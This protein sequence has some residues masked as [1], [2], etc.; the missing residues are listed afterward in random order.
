M[1]VVFDH[2]IIGDLAGVSHPQNFAF[3]QPTY[4]D[5]YMYDLS[6][7]AVI[8]IFSVVKF[9]LMSVDLVF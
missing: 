5:Q 1:N 9:Y 4:L 6:T 7:T 2:S 8:P 3:G